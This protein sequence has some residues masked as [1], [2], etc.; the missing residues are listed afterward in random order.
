M[1]RSIQTM[2]R[3][4]ATHKSILVFAEYGLARLVT[5]TYQRMWSML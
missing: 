3:N 4:G 5:T 2:D 1:A